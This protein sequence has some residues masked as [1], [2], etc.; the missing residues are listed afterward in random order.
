MKSRILLTLFFIT[1]V[2]LSS[3]SCVPQVDIRGEAF[4]ALEQM[5]NSGL[6]RMDAEIAQFDQELLDID[7]RVTKLEQ[8][9]P[10]A[11][12]WIEEKKSGDY[13]VPCG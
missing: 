1:V 6:K 13:D 9:I 4:V 11:E 2:A 5:Y 12:K 10:Q 3:L 7:D 8:I